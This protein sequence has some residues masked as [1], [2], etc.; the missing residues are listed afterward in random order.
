M[1]IALNKRQLLVI[2]LVLLSLLLTTF[3]IIHGAIPGLWHAILHARLA[4]I[5]RYS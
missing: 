5:N 4:V 3:L 2:V 1:S